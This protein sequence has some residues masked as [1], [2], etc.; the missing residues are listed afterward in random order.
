M[1]KY[2]EYWTESWT[3]NSNKVY[4]YYYKDIIGN[5]FKIT[6]KEVIIHNYSKIYG[7]NNK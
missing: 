5:K 4:V 2:L 6:N 1:D 7:T 3:D